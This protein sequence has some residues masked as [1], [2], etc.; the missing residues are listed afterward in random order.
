MNWHGGYGG[1][2]LQWDFGTDG[3]GREDLWSATGRDGEIRICERYTRGS[4]KDVISLTYNISYSHFFFSRIIS[5]SVLIPMKPHPSSLLPIQHDKSRALTNQGSRCTRTTPIFPVPDVR[6]RLSLA[7]NRISR[8]PS[9]SGRRGRRSPCTVICQHEAN[10]ESPLC[11]LS[12]L[13]RAGTSSFPLPLPSAPHHRTS[14]R[15]RAIEC[16]LWLT[17]TKLMRRRRCRRRRHQ[18]WLNVN[19]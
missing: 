9:R 12:L 1:S 16:G 8:A 17:R 11:L 2:F 6:P 13:P 15:R 18:R 19:R 4:H 3:T 10:A 5:R 14:S 7:P